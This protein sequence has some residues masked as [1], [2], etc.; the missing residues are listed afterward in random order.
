MRWWWRRHRDT[1]GDENAAAA[2]A[3]A[4]A[5]AKERAVKRLTPIVEQYADRLGDLS[6]EEL[7]ARVARAFQRRPA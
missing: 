2:A 3:K 4:E 5:Q 7:V 1:N 6:D